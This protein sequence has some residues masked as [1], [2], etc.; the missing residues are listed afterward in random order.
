MLLTIENSILQLNKYLLQCQVLFCSIQNVDCDISNI[1]ML[2]NSFLSR[3]FVCFASLSG[4]TGKCA[5]QSIWKYVSCIT[6]LMFFTLLFFSV[7]LLWSG[8][9]LRWIRSYYG[10]LEQKYSVLHHCTGNT[11]EY[12]LATQLCVSSTESLLSTD[13]RETKYII[14]MH[15]FQCLV[16]VSDS[17]KSTFRPQKK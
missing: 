6:L 2:K 17:T 10:A 13:R 15:Q 1:T 14:F 7:L 3:I 9:W 11:V 5:V 4:V 12:L 8:G 16:I